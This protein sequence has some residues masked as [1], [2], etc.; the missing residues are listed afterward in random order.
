VPAATVV[1]P[2][3]ISQFGIQFGVSGGG[4]FAGGDIFVD[5]ITVCGGTEGC[6][7]TSTGSFDF[8]T[9]GS[10]DSWAFK[11]DT[12]VTDTVV[13]QSGDQHYGSSGSGSLK[14][15]MTAIPV[16]P[17]ATT[18]TTRLVE[19]Y[20]AKAYCGQTVTYHVMADKVT[21]L[22]V[23]PYTS[24]NGWAFLTGTAVT[25]TAINTWTEVK[26][27]IPTINFLGVQSVGLQLG[28]TSTSAAY[29]GNV[30]IDGISW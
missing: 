1:F 7:G 5:S 4:S 27:T 18:S 20:K 9:A 25:L 21:G 19:L 3:G 15:A 22:S 29:T 28:N 24:A 6:S 23:Q 12:A 16:A 26:F 30:Y 13:T 14:V 11:G 8:E 10:P 2:G 17:S